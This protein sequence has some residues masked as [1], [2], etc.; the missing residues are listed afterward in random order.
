VTHPD[1]PC[2]PG[3]GEDL[4]A[5]RALARER[6]LYG[7]PNVLTGEPAP[8][9]SAGTVSV[10]HGSPVV[11]GSGTGW[12]PDLAGATLRLDGDA[13]AYVIAAVLAPDKLV[14][15]RDYGGVAGSSKVYAIVRDDHF[16]HLHDHLTHLVAG[17]TAAGP[18]HVRYQPVPAHDEGTISVTEGSSTVAGAGTGWDAALEDLG[19][20]VTESRGT[21]SITEDEPEVVK[22]SGTNWGSDLA[23]QTFEVSGEQTQYTVVRVDS[24]NR[25]TLDQSYRGTPGSGK[26]YTIT[27]PAF[28][29]V[30]SVD[31]PFAASGTDGGQLRLSSQAGGV[32]LRLVSPDG[33]EGHRRYFLP[34]DAYAPVNGARVLRKADGTGFFLLV[35]AA[36]S[37]AGTHLSIGQYRLGLTYRR[38]NRNADSESLV[39]SQA[40]NA[41]TEEARIDVPWSMR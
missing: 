9:H 32:E 26:G 36:S 17:G 29:T 21:V 33:A 38:D 11:T 14:L 22:G 8:I 19:L 30:A 4:R 20:S 27:G 6:V 16:A 31:S 7:D 35:P 12:E 28:Y 3:Q 1:Y 13:T 37:S 10:V 5:A 18:M 40:G 34:D 41:K 24:P 25:L 2:T 23:G 15:G 39:L